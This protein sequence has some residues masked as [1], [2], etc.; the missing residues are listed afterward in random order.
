MWEER[1]QIEGPY[2]F[3]LILER[4]SMDPL[5]AVDVNN[6]TVKVPIY[7]PEREVATIQAVGEVEAPE[8]IIKGRNEKTKESVQEKLAHIFQ[9]HVSLKDVDKHFA[10]TDLHEIFAQHRGTPL[11][12]DFSP[13]TCLIK[14]IIHQQLNLK[15][16]MTLTERFVH[17]FGEEI[18][19]V[20]FY[21]T[22]EKTASLAI[23][24]LRELQFSQRKA[25]YAIGLSQ[26][27][28][29]GELNLEELSVESDEMI[30]KTLVKIRGIGPWTAQNFLL[31]GLG[32]PNLFPIGDVGIQ[33]AL[34]KLYKLEAK[35]DHPA[36]E[37]FSEAWKPY[38]SYAS[39]YLWRSIETTE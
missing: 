32:R 25:E 19:G 3:D 18:D 15:F 36:M 9:W 4:L 28:V 23:E 14:C 20:W 26:M 22:P 2:H 17:T 31:F 8:F 1:L 12:L 7:E 5:N 21:P 6:R 27:I 13:Y 39:L 35:P 29:N 16:A 33:N 37:Q 11:I 38:L 24:E 30:M 10:E 34:K